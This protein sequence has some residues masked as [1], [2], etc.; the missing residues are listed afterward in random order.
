MILQ[1][2]NSYYQRMLDDPDAEIPAFGTSVEN[3]SS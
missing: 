3:I 2:L 1:A